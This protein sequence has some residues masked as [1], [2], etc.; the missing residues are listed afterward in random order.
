MHHFDQKVR[1][2]PGSGRTYFQALGHW[3]GEIPLSNVVDS[4]HLPRMPVLSVDERAVVCV[5]ES[6]VNVT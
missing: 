2:F 3:G 6:G 4:R 5:F 1:H